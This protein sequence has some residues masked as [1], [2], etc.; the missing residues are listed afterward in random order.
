[1][2][3]LVVQPNIKMATIAKEEILTK[4]DSIN[5]TCKGDKLVIKIRKKEIWNDIKRSIVKDSNGNVKFEHI[6]LKGIDTSTDPHQIK[7]FYEE[8]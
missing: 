7:F 8:F 3:L 6:S 2:K 4:I 1:M 5:I